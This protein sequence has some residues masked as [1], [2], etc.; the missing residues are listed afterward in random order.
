MHFTIAWNI[1][2]DDVSFQLTKNASD[3]PGK[4]RITIARINKDLLIKLQEPILQSV[5]S[6]MLLPLDIQLWRHKYGR[7][8]EY[9]SFYDLESDRRKR[10]GSFRASEGGIWELRINVETN[11]IWHFN[12]IGD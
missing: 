7:G 3:S 9:F 2:S 6:K 5:L 11:E 4:P 8:L 12:Y 1:G 10:R